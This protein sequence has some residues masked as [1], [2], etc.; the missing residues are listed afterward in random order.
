MTTSPIN[1]A[2]ASSQ[3]ENLSG[4]QLDPIEPQ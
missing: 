1:E 2:E 4:A 3:K